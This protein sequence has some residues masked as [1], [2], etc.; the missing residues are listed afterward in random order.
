MA[1]NKNNTGNRSTGN[2]S[3]GDCST[4]DYSTGSYSTGDYST[5]SCSTGHYSTGSYSTGY[6]S[7]GDYSTGDCSTGHFSTG[8][9]STGDYSTGSCSTGDYSTGWYS[10]GNCSTGRYSV[11]HFCNE[12]Y[13]PHGWFNVASDL[14][15]GDVDTPHFSEFY[16]T[17]W[18]PGS[19]MTTQEKKDNSTFHTTGG[20]LKTYEYKEAWANFWAKTDQKN[21][22]KF[23]KLPH[24]DAEVFEDITG[25]NV[26]VTSDCCGK[27]VEIEGRKYRLVLED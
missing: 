18:V 12:E 20:Y 10:T 6:C 2:R 11:G 26:N 3:T 25:I 4:G 21:K 19:D 15:W 9:Y 13:A 24:F 22:D 16:V 8:S 14:R 5:G 27:L 7:T 1:G 17:Q 23:L